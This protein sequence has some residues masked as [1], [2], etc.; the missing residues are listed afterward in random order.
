MSIIFLWSARLL[1]L[2]MALHLLILNLLES[3]RMWVCPKGK[4]PYTK[5]H[6]L[7]F[8]T[9]SCP[10]FSAKSYI[11]RRRGGVWRRPLLKLTRFSVVD[12]LHTEGLLLQER[13]R[14]HQGE[15]GRQRRLL[16]R[17]GIALVAACGSGAAYGGVVWRRQPP[18]AASSWTASAAAT[19]ASSIRT[20][21]LCPKFRK[22][23]PTILSFV[24]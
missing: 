8:G 7:T 3:F 22:I 15:G 1:W 4:N 12:I 24:I 19:P 5:V 2:E 20:S 18:A 13:P 9:Y 23:C 14:R 10:P 11:V 16:C 21:T 17:R 6:S